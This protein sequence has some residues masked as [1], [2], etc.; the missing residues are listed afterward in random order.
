M[1]NKRF[2]YFCI[3]LSTLSVFYL[4]T[5]SNIPESNGVKF[6][7]YENAD[8]GYSLTFSSE[9]KK[10]IETPS[11]PFNVWF[12]PSDVLLNKSKVVIEEDDID[13]LFYI[14]VSKAM[15]ISPL[16]F[17]QDDQQQ[18]LE[19]IY[20]N[21]G[22]EDIKIDQQK[23]FELAN[24]KGHHIEYEYK[25]PNYGKIKEKNIIITT[26]GEKYY[27]LGFKAE[28]KEY[29]KLLPSI[30]HIMTS[31]RVEQEPMMKEATGSE[32]HNLLNRLN[33][34]Q[35]F[36]LATLQD[37]IIQDLETTET[38]ENMHPKTIYEVLLDMSKTQTTLLDALKKEVA[39]SLEP[40]QCKVAKSGAQAALSYIPAAGPIIAQVLK[41]PIEEGLNQVPGLCK[42][43]QPKQEQIQISAGT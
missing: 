14:N 41:G 23:S 37:K 24:N 31:F 38:R 16:L 4:I 27:L 43:E 28:K 6:E 3:F 19:S 25:L 29:D 7:K 36:M 18:W 42:Q 32:I 9:W 40:V 11:D 5:S 1:I 8:Y 17:N 20:E 34:T 10:H 13:P 26:N 33:N 21:K 22:A 39:P 35:N 12:Q 15:A 30:Q 2:N